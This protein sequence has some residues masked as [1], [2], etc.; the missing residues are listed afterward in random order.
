MVALIRSSSLVGIDAVA[1]EV[2]CS[3]AAGQLPSYSVVGLAAPSVKEGAVRIRSALRAIGHDLP[4]KRVTVNLAPADLRK[5]GCALDLPIALAI[6]IADEV[7]EPG[8][9]LD[10]LVLGELGLEGQIR[11]VNGV[12][13]A[14]MLARER[15]MRGVIV[16]QEV[17]GEALLVEGIEVYGVDHISQIFKALTE[18]TELPFARVAEPRRKRKRRADLVDMS[19]VRGQHAAREAIEIAVAGGH[20]LLL[21]GPPGTGK[22]MLAR[23]LSTV[24][25]MMTRNEALETTKIYSAL[26]L[27]DGGLIEERPFRSPHH[28]I[29]S[30]ALLGGGTVPR[31]GEISLAH[32]GVLFLDELPEFS[33]NAIEGLREPLEERAVSVIRVNGMLRLPASFLLVAAAN[34]CPCGWLGTEARE[35]TCSR[36]AIERYRSRLSG[37]LLDR[38]DLQVVVNPV[39]LEELRSPWPGEPS[40]TVRERVMEARDRQVARLASFGIRCNAEMTTSVQRATCPLTAVCEET[41]VEIVEQRQSLTARS[42]DRL[43][44]VARTIA[45]LDGVDAITPQHLLDAADYRTSDPLS[46]PVLDASKNSTL[47]A[48]AIARAASKAVVAAALSGVDPQPALST[49]PKEPAHV[50]PCS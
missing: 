23:R 41:L 21:A 3:I 28:T 38:I 16:P 14:A 10:L 36:F 22:T 9:L 37:P 40:K 2:E 7:C 5:N 13:A 34:P 20:N 33:R 24:L 29:S 32:N 15:G 30:A 48:K 27:V 50:A 31:A 47:E 25:P 49:S 42:I 43:I 44:K 1:V 8:P 11:R 35:C 45:D 6:L 19:E 4:L 12:L 17:A 46:D 26:G 39:K 18:H